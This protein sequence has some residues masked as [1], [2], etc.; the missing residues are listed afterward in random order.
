MYLIDSSAWIEFLRPQGSARVKNRIREIVRTDAAVSCGIVV[1][2][3]LRGTKTDK[4]FATVKEALMAL[5]QIAISDEVIERASSWGYALDRKGKQA[6][7]T[8][9]IIAAAAYQ[10]ACLLHMDSDFER[11]ASMFEVQ[12]EH[13]S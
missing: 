2:E 6:S 10:K 1:I 13:I 3:V 11:I 5:P 8:G 12:T 4:D 9:L 7:T